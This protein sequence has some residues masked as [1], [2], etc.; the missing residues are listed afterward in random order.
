MPKIRS[1]KSR[2]EPMCPIKLALNA[3][4]TPLSISATLVFKSTFK[5]VREAWGAGFEAVNVDEEPGLSA[6][7]AKAILDDYHME[8]ASGFFQGP[9]YFAEEEE[10]IFAAAVHKAEFAQALGQTCLFVSAL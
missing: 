4:T 2:W 10:R 3:D 9:F 1:E 7:G 5:R 6:D 8:I